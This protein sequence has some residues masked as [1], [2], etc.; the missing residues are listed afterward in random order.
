MGICMITCGDYQINTWPVT[1]VR[2]STMPYHCSVITLHR[3]AIP[4]PVIRVIH[5][6]ACSIDGFQL[7]R[8]QINTDQSPYIHRQIIRKR[9]SFSLRKAAHSAC[10]AEIMCNLM[11]GGKR[12]LLYKQWY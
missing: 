9:P 8:L 12:V 4:N 5:S 2:G 11:F 6:E 10:F 3:L 1:S 7:Q